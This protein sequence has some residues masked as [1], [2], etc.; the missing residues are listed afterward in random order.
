MSQTWGLCR[1]WRCSRPGGEQEVNPAFDMLP[2]TENL[3]DYFADSYDESLNGISPERAQLYRLCEQNQTGITVMKG[4]AGGRLL[5]S[6]TSP[7]GTALTPVQCLHY[8][9]TRPAVASVMVGF[10]T[11]EHVD[12][13]VAYETASMEEKD[14]A[15]VLAGA[16]RHGYYGQCTY[17]GHCA[18]CPAGIDIAMVN[19]LCD[20]ALMQE[21]LPDTL[22]AHYSQLSANADACVSCHSCESRCPFG[23]RIAERMA[24]TKALF[25]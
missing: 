2:A 17:C 14:Y 6:E 4:Y 23:V 1:R 19:K 3:D 10:D 22:K 11:V 5:K 21:K 12:A 9:L 13:A 20:L 18:P 25:G 24:K 7:F 16:P 15:S 8:A